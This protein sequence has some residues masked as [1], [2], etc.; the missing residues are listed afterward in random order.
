[1]GTGRRT[2]AT[3]PR[4]LTGVLDGEGIP[5]LAARRDLG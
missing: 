1:M 5:T 4:V 2:T 3:D